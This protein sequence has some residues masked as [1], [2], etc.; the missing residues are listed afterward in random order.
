MR[1]LL[2]TAALI[3]LLMIA[4]VNHA[5]AQLP[6]LGEV[7][8]F[9]FNWCPAHWAAADG[10]MLRISENTALFSLIGTYYGGNGTSTFALP[11]LSGRAPYGQSHERPVGSEYGSPISLIGAAQGTALSL[12]WCVAMSGVYPTRDT[13]PAA[14]P[15]T[16]TPPTFTACSAKDYPGLT[17]G[18]GVPRYAVGALNG[19]CYCGI[20][21]DVSVEQAVEEGWYASCNNGKGICNFAPG[22]HKGNQVCQ[23]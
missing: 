18:P 2:T 16:V 6:Y 9:G 1:L 8:L 10:T 14:P 12:N 20:W 23:P 11:N 13:V 21:T 15:H 4:S 7:R 19:V 5:A 22:T 17:F 3:S